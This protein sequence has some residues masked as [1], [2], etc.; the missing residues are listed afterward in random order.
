M[1]ACKYFTPYFF[2]FFLTCQWCYIVQAT[3]KIFA[4][5]EA[6]HT[7]DATSL[8]WAASGASEDTLSIFCQLD[9]TLSGDRA[10]GCI[11]E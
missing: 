8:L 7:N 4:S 6:I 11:I 1:Y 3:L 9:A 2:S 5:T 10:R